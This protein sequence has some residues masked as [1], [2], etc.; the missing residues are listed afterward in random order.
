MSISVA[1]S[2]LE[3]LRRDLAGAVSAARE[4]EAE[5]GRLRGTLTEMQTQLARARQDQEAYQQLIDAKQRAS[6]SASRL[7]D[8]ILGRLRSPM[9]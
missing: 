2:E 5:A 4:A 6:A 1:D 9:Q 8:R 3:Q 7:K